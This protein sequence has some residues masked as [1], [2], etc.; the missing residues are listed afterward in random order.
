MCKAAN[1]S[2]QKGEDVNAKP[3]AYMY[4]ILFMMSMP[5]TICGGFG[6]AF[7]RITKAAQQNGDVEPDGTDDVIA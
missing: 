2:D 6:F 3:R 4:S 5:A 1:E 7:W